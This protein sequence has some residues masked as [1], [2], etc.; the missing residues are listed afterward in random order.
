[1]KN[2]LKYILVFLS[3]SFKIVQLT[4]G[5]TCE[6]PPPLPP[7]VS[8]DP[9][10]ILGISGYGEENYIAKR[11]YLNYTVYFENDAELATAPAQEIL[12]KDTLDLS[13]FNP[14]NFS[15]GTFT[16]R[17]VTIEAT[18]GVT[19]FSHDVDMRSKGEEII[20]R[21]QGTFD[22]TTGEVRCYMIALDP[23]TMDLTESPYLGVL[24]PNTTPPIGDGNFT[25]RIGLR[26]DVGDGAV[27]KNQGHITFDL[28]EPIATNVYV[29]TIDESRPVSSMSFN[30]VS[31]KENTYAIA[32]EGTDTGSGVRDYSV[33]VQEDD[34]GFFLWQINT[35]ATSGE[36]T[37]EPGKTYEF[38]CV[39]TDNVGN[40][41]GHKE[42]E[43]SFTTTDINA[44]AIDGLT[45]HPNPVKDRLYIESAS[46]VI[47][48]CSIV[49]ALGESVYLSMD[50]TQK[51]EIDMEIYPAGVYI[52]KIET[53]N[54]AALRKI[55]KD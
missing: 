11:N 54:G 29:N 45:I 43:I 30:L 22:K 37:G 26:D 24:Y 13:K 6:L 27:I 28:N 44:V 7:I 40:T 53:D 42:A 2:F 3:F 18:P 48:S 31:S 33:Y 10:E 5:Q 16:F 8:V 41:E 25:Y 19:E 50:K 9:N 38:Y 34:G 47:T 1:M 49:N 20:V 23:V 46:A 21:I 14:D 55:I 35:P 4:Y 32:W 51:L 39:A 15:F 52:L 36:F 12:V 17:D